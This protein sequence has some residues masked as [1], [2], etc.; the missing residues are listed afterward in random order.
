MT[1][2]QTNNQPRNQNKDFSSIKSR[3]AK[4]IHDTLY[5]NCNP[6]PDS[7]VIPYDSVQPE[8]E[9]GWARSTVV[10]V[11]YCPK[12]KTHVVNIRFQYDKFGKF[13][14]HT[15]EYV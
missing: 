1:N 7:I 10:Y 6:P 15:Q 14:S 2:T 9:A 4:S 5:R 11:V 8:P 12:K 13:L 3:L